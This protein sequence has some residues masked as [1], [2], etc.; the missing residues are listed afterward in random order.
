MN[1]SF[2]S[3]GNDSTA[4]LFQD[5]KCILPQPLTLLRIPYVMSYFSLSLPHLGLTKFLGCLCSYLSSYLLSFLPLLLQIV[6]LPLSLSQNL[7]TH[8][9]MSHRPLQSL[10][11]FLFS[12]LLSNFIISSSPLTPSFLL[13]S[14][15]QPLQSTSYLSDYTVLLWNVVCFYSLC[16]F[17]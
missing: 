3:S 16:L 7:T 13:K 10:L 15:E 17:S 12:V 14:V 1:F 5:F 6:F 11:S 2:C 4:F 8:R 9:F